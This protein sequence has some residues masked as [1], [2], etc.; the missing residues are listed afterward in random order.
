MSQ[1]FHPLLVKIVLKIMSVY[2]IMQWFVL[3]LGLEKLINPFVRVDLQ[4]V[5]KVT[6][7]LGDPIETMRVLREKKNIF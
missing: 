1:V 3:I 6:G 2:E 4:V 7:T 5:Q